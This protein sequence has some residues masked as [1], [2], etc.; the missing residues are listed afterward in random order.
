MGVVPSLLI[1]KIQPLERA[2]HAHLKDTAPRACP[3]C[4]SYRYS[5]S[6]VTSLLFLK[7]QLLGRDL[8]A[9]LK[10]TALRA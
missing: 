7:I 10:D 2:L 1:L 3:P 6:G 8:L 9:L 4:S 5:P